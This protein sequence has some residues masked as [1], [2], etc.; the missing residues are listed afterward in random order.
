MNYKFI[1]GLLLAT[2]TLSSCDDGCV[3]CTGKTADQQICEGDYANKTD[4]EAY[5]RHY[6][7][8][9]GVCE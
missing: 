3:Q 6:E 2:V 8:A 9:G 5:I 1:I 7:E 4:Y